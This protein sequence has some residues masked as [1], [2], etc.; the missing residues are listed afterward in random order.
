MK[1]LEHL[2]P[3]A[4]FAV[5]VIIAIRNRQESLALLEF[6]G[7]AAEFANA[8]SLDANHG[9]VIINATGQILEWN[10]AMEVL[11]RFTAADML[12]GRHS[13]G[14]VI[15]EESRAAH[16]SKI[17]TAFASDQLVGK[18]VWRVGHVLDSRGQQHAVQITLR[19]LHTAHSGL[20]AEVNIDRLENVIPMESLR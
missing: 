1:V 13:L 8:S 3:W 17:T 5:V 18:L 7:T 20:I 9:V 6:H 15:P 12:S 19:M 10:R 4:C 16:N 11:T 14:E 2:M